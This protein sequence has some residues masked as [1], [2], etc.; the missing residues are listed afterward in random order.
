MPSLFMHNGQ[1]AV[2]K[3]NACCVKNRG[4][5]KNGP[6]SHDSYV[7]EIYSVDCRWNVQEFVRRKE[8]WWLILTSLSMWMVPKIRVGALMPNGMP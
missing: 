5:M 1:D 4:R 2:G 8:K 6:D 7:A 3:I